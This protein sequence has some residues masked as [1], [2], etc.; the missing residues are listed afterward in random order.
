MVLQGAGCWSTML[1]YML[2]FDLITY[3]V[4]MSKD[5]SWS[6]CASSWQKMPF[7]Q[8]TRP[9]LFCIIT[10]CMLLILAKKFREGDQ[11]I[12][13]LCLKGTSMG[14]V[15]RWSPRRMVQGPSLYAPRKN[16]RG[17][18]R[19]YYYCIFV[20]AK[21]ELL[22]FGTHCFCILSGE[23]GRI[24]IQSSSPDHLPFVYVRVGRAGDSR[25]GNLMESLILGGCWCHSKYTSSP[26]SLSCFKLM[27]QLVYC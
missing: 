7:G 22:W 9:T 8:C 2:F 23:W 19:A 10:P 16:L 5:L 6:T 27:L 20:W 1:I 11:S 17:W 18:R 24:K 3:L 26:L 21:L 14:C 13:L 4:S 12:V 25:K 15:F